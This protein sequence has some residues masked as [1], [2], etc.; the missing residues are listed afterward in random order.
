MVIYMKDNLSMGNLKAK[1]SLC[2]LMVVYMMENLKQKQHKAEDFS[3]TRLVK[4]RW[5]IYE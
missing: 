3:C 5:R 4:R 2:P 1:E